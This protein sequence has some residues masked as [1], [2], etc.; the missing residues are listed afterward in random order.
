MYPIQAFWLVA[1]AAADTIA[2]WPLLWISLASRSTSLVP[3]CAVDAWF[4]NRLRQLG[5][6]ES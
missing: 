4:T 3:I 5:A 2:I 6:S 1:D